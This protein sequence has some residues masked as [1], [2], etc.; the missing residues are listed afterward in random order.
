MKKEKI[1]K[2]LKQQKGITLIALVVTIIILIILA[3]ISIGA[4]LGDNGL[5][6]MATK[7]R[8]EH[9]QAEEKEQ[10]LLNSAASYIDN[11]GIE[12]GKETGGE[13]GGGTTGGTGE[14]YDD[15]TGGNL[16]VDSNLLKIQCITDM[17]YPQIFAS[18]ITRNLTNENR[19]EI[20]VIKDGQINE[21]FTSFNSVLTKSY[22]GDSITG[23]IPGKY[24]GNPPA[25]T[26]ANAP[27]A[28]EF[29]TNADEMIFFACGYLRIS[30]DKGNG[31]VMSSEE[32]VYTGSSGAL[33]YVDFGEGSNDYKNIRIETEGNIGAFSIM[34]GKEIKKVENTPKK[35]LFIGDSWTEGV[36]IDTGK[37]YLSYSNIIADRLNMLCINDGVGGAGYDI[38]TPGDANEGALYS[39]INMLNES[40]DHFEPDVIVINGGGNDISNVSKTTDAI[41][42]KADELYTRLEEYKKSHSGCKVVILGVEYIEGIQE[43]E[44]TRE[45]N[46]KL[47]EKAKAH[48]FPYIDYVTGDTYGADGTQI[49]EGN[50][51]YIT[52]TNRSQYLYTD[53]THPTQAG[54]KYLSEA[55]AKEVEK[56]LK[57]ID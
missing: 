16:K 17:W 47:I 39:Y 45:L 1:I 35:I 33:V 41:A 3:T 52:E 48:Q 11:M 25:E 23:W 26:M 38:A 20:P 27:F 53:N 43:Y 5:I 44:R 31:Y 12:D 37:K 34:Q 21:V 14:E 57:S 49:T 7:A 29:K 46:S 30:V 15:V 6:N 10:E 9:E 18:N 4:I 51:P 13:S 50:G 42:Q 32:G 54:H 24:A 19:N 36:A 2:R 8:D 22:G 28:L 56:A 55:L 40:L